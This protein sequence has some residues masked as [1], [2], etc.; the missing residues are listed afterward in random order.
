MKQTFNAV[1]NAFSGI[2]KEYLELFGEGIVNGKD[3]WNAAI[4]KAAEVATD[5]GGVT[6]VDDEIRKLKI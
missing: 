1:G 4:E 5:C 3:V 6:Y 2:T